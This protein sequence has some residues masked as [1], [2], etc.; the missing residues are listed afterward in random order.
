MNNQHDDGVIKF[1]FNLKLTKA[2]NEELYI[3]LE[4]W[5]VIFHKMGLIGEYPTNKV[6]Y[7]NLSKREVSGSDAF[8]ITGT[9]TGK[10]ANLNGSY[11]TKITKCDLQKMSLEAHGPI[12][13]SSESLTHYGIYKN[14]SHINFVF[15]V[16]HEKLWKYMLANEYDRTPQDTPY[17]TQEMANQVKICIGHKEQGILAMAGHTDG[18]ISYGKNA[19]QA[20][21]ILLETLKKTR[22]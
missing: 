21:Q 2:L 18:V 15:H 1:K 22:T 19:E 10:Y 16:H 5:R 9:Q 12:A 14:F 4:K 3:Q 17:G 7:G 13:P 6:G 8:I 20:G 11:Y